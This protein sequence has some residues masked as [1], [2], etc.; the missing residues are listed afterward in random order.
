MAIGCIQTSR[1]DMDTSPLCFCFSEPC[2]CSME[3]YE[4]VPCFNSPYY[5]IWLQWKKKVKDFFKYIYCNFIEL[6]RALLRFCEI[7]YPC[8]HLVEKSKEPWK[9]WFLSLVTGGLV[10]K[11]TEKCFCSSRLL[12]RFPALPFLSSPPL[13]TWV[14]LNEF[15]QDLAAKHVYLPRAIPFRLPIEMCGL[16][17]L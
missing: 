9:Y 5:Y 1:N 7:W 11:G 16:I 12:H 17:L 4:W 8:C 2:N 6:C 10:C 13:I 14:L 15:L 3:K